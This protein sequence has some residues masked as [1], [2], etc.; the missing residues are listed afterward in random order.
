MDTELT[1]RF[2]KLDFRDDFMF[3]KVME[4]PV[5]CR[6]VMECLLQHPVGK[7]RA[8]STEKEFRYTSNG[9][10]VRM[11]IFNQ[12]S[13][14]DVFDVEMQNR[15]KKAVQALHLPQRI[16]FYQASIDIDYLNRNNNY[17]KLPKSSILFICT[18][19]PFQWGLSQYHFA[20]CCIEEPRI[21]LGDG[22]VKVFFNCR[23]EGNDI[24]DDLKKFYDYVMKGTAVHGAEHQLPLPG[25]GN[26]PVNAWKRSGT[27]PDI[28]LWVY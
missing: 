8:V 23:Y 3:K 25:Q 1:E 7:I 24:P 13:E 28:S 19:D 22:T 14:G 9:K 2:R 12:N 6:E 5:L 11:D 26:Q 10:P 18:F 16:R 15:N 20:E 27:F 21:R 17:E 4:D